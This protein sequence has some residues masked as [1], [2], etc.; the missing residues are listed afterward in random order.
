[1]LHPAKGKCRG[2]SFYAV[3]RQGYHVTSVKSRNHRR[4]TFRP[5]N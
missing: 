4:I 1:M 3:P 2:V 5:G